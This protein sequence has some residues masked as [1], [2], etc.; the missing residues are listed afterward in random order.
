MKKWYILLLVIVLAGCQSNPFQQTHVEIDWVDFIKWDGVEYDGILEGVLANESFIG[1]KIGEVNFKVADNVS[2]SN[3][4]IKDGDAAF[5]E[6]G[7]A[8]YEIKG[9]PGFLAVKDEGAINGYRV[10][11]A[12][13]EDEEYKW[14]FKDMPIDKVNRIQIYQSYTAQG[15]SLVNEIESKEEVAAFMKLLLTSETNSSFSPNTQNGD[16]T[17]Y[18]IVLY[19]GEPIAY[20]YGMAYDGKTYFWSP[21]DTSI[22]SND[23]E[24]YMK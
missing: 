24:K 16:P 1:K 21:W 13:S 3:Y 8:L 11:Y 17:Y 23:M 14:H 12:R 7:T 19:T 2:D 22:L 15:N 4:R 18:D 5:H 9:L 20:K 6:K 10:Y